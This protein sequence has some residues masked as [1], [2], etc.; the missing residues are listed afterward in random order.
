MA[1]IETA[2]IVAERHGISRDR[3]DEFSLESQKR[4]AAAQQ[5][6]KFDNEIV[7]METKMIVVDRG[8]QGPSKSVAYVVDEDEGNR[9]ETTL[10]GLKSLPPVFK[11]GQKVRK[12]TVRHRRQRLA[13]FRT[14]PP[15]CC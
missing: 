6:G 3:Q 8:D 2:E 13:A 12:G 1:M 4:T 11:D 7:P 14:A 9:P 5:A 15:P 10:G